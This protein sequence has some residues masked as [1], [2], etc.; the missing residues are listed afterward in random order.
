MSDRTDARR[1]RILKDILANGMTTPLQLANLFNART[2]PTVKADLA[3]IEKDTG[4]IAYLD[5]DTVISL[6]LFLDSPDF[7]K[8]VKNSHSEK[9]AMANYAVN[10]FIKE[11]DII[12]L[13]GGSTILEIA[14]SL[15]GSGIND[16][17]VITNNLFALPC[18]L[19]RVEKLRTIAGLVDKNRSVLYDS[20]A[21]DLEKEGFVTSF[22]SGNELS[23]EG[24]SCQRR[25][26]KSKREIISATKSLTVFMIDHTK[27]RE[28]EGESVV[29]F[30]E[31]DERHKEYFVITDAKAKGHCSLEKRL[32][33]R[34]IIAPLNERR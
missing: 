30:E 22:I 6:L 12:F 19:G 33:K 32:G 7:C 15:A 2:N 10:N 16:L 9:R 28:L 5:K 21:C 14:V 20:P 1:Y 34:L 17:T 25:Y 26:V 24:I 27:I 3:R 13:D 4:S 18:L 29:S 23:P 31:L 8:R 11:D